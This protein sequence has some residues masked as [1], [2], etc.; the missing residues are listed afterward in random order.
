MLQMNRAYARLLSKLLWLSVVSISLLAMP[1]WP[2]VRPS[3]R[4]AWQSGTKTGMYWQPVISWW[5][6]KASDSYRTRDAGE[7]WFL[8]LARMH[9]LRVRTLLR[10]RRPRLL[11]RT[12][13]AA[14]QRR[15]VGSAFA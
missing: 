9:W 15:V 12:W 5:H 7:I 6:V 3:P 2:P 13:R 4:Q 1:G 8:L 14:W 10:I 11:K